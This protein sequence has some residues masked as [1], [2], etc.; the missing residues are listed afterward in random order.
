MELAFR[1]FH[2]ANF[3]EWTEKDTYWFVLKSSHRKPKRHVR[4]DFF[5]SIIMSRRIIL[6]Q[7]T[8]LNN[9]LKKSTGKMNIIKK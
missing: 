9:T 4:V 7:L 3:S 1:D 2:C 5:S 6:A 8:L